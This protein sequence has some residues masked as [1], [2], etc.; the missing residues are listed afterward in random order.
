MPSLLYPFPQ[1]HEKST[2]VYLRQNGQMQPSSHRDFLAYHSYRGAISPPPLRRH[3]RLLSPST[4]TGVPLISRRRR[5]RLFIHR[6]RLILHPPV[7]PSPRS[8]SRSGPG[9]RSSTLTCHRPISSSSVSAVWTIG[10]CIAVA[11]P[12]AAT[13]A[14][15]AAVAKKDG[16]NDDNDNNADDD[17]DGSLFGGDAAASVAGLAAAVAGEEYSHG[18]CG[19]EKEGCHFCWLRVGCGFGWGFVVMSP[20]R[21]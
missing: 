11:C 14:T 13:L 8:R 19:G 10:S 16:D 6:R 15:A 9:P 4:I 20:N 5:P 18:F 17:D 12:G 21:L 2:L 3:R 7:C 1:R